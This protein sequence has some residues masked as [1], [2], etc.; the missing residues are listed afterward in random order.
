MSA[1]APAPI[2]YLA[3][4]LRPVHRRM[5]MA[6]TL[7]LVFG[8]AS[9]ILARVSSQLVAH[10]QPLEELSYY[11]SGEHLEPATLGHA[12]SAADLAW[13]RAVQY[14]GGH[15][16][17]DNRFV[18]MEHVFDILTTL[19]PGF[20]PAYVFGSFALAQEGG[21]FPAAERLMEKGLRA[22]PRSGDL[23]FQAGFLYYVKTGGRDFRNAGRCFAQAAR[24]PDAPPEAA[25]F[26]AFSEQQ[27]G[28]LSVAYELWHDVAVRSRNKY[29]RDMAEEQ[30]NRI[31]EAIATG[32]PQAV[33][34]HMP[35]PVVLIK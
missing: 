32:K 7:A 12:E 5:M 17:T 1:A 13:L 23:A 30:M 34:R 29:L 25:R 14:Y 24:Q 8:A 26:A 20:L 28:E 27:S 15:R 9:Y 19:V 18:K 3:G 33:V 22:N 2:P 16:Y 4:G 21:D 10:P 31:R 11:P 6:W 35:T